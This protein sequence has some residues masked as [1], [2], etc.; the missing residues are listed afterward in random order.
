MSR[1]NAAFV[2][3]KL[4]YVIA[5]S[6]RS[7]APDRQPP[8]RRSHFEQRVRGYH[9]YAPVA[10][11]ILSADIGGQPCVRMNDVKATALYQTLYC[12]SR[13][14]YSPEAARKLRQRY[15]PYSGRQRARKL[16]ACRSYRNT[17]AKFG[18]LPRQLEYMRFR[19][20]VSH[21]VCA[22]KNIHIAPLPESLYAKGF[23][24]NIMPKIRI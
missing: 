24:T 23:N 17:V 3:E 5:Y 11:R 9:K 19:P 18:K 4:F 2:N 13:S 21:R 22:Q 1:I 8:K 15:M 10:A 7:L 20:A 12:E 16:A 6:N 14:D